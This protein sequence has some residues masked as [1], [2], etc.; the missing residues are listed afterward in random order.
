MT[1]SNLPRPSLARLATRS[2]LWTGLS[3]YFLFGLGFVKTI[4]LFRL[5]DVEYFN[6]LAVATV[7]ASY[8]TFPRLDLRVAVLSGHEDP[9][10][11]DTQ[12]WLETLSVGLSFIVATALF[13]IWPGIVT[14]R[15]VW[16]LIYALLFVSLFEAL[17]S[18]PLYLIEKRLRQDVLG[19][20][21][22]VASLVG[23]SVPMIL[24]YRGA[25][26]EALV[27]DVVIP[28]FITNLSVVLFV[29]WRPMW[30]WDQHQVREQL[31]LGWTLLSTGLM[32]KIIFQ[33]DDLLVS[34]LNRPHP[35]LWL[36][37]GGQVAEGFYSRAYITGKMP[38][39]VAG[40]IIG[41]IALSLYAEGALRGREVLVNVYRQ[42][43]WLLAW[44]I[45]ASSALAFVISDEVVRLLLTDKWLPM[46]PL[47]RLMFIFV[48]G[49]PLFQNNS[50]VLQAIRAEKD[51]RR[52]VA[53]QAVFI[54]VVCPLAV[55]WWGAA[56]ASVVVSVMTVLGLVASEWYVARHLGAAVWRCYIAPV[57]ACVI[58]IGGAAVLANALSEN[59]WLSLVAK[60]LLC[61]AIFGLFLLLFERQSLR[62]NW[63]ILRR[64]LSRK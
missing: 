28:I 30:R 53:W 49:R 47:F 27:A 41:R 59:I 52:A 44:I 40:G 4:L 51:F 36:S 35:V 19:R 8:L 10:V 57:C 9:A 1:D 38:M 3:Q 14:Q 61:I 17:T 43:T 56:G 55:Y 26:L 46:V 42:L 5:I 7:W 2:A 16:L 58:T 31:K 50:Q 25:Y 29:R 64:G 32:G 34:T 60:G 11:L 15:G 62:E 22:I 6:L 63:G 45:F 18:T 37:S 21:S 24:A 13:L 48:V 33:F 12:F 39:D 20:T 23:F 54:L